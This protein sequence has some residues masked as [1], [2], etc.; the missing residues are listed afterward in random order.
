MGDGIEGKAKEVEQINKKAKE[1]NRKSGKRELEG[2]KERV[3][4]VCKRGCNEFLSCVSGRGC[5][6]GFEEEVE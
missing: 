3:A 1:E 6:K 4:V 5:E 2:D